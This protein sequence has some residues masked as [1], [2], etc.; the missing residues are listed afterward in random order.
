MYY[1]QDTNNSVTVTASSTGNPGGV[2]NHGF[3]SKSFAGASQG[4]DSLYHYST[5]TLKVGETADNYIAYFIMITTATYT[6]D[7]GG[8][9]KLQPGPQRQLRRYSR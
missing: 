7:A 4:Y 6:V 2:R 5:G 8:L 3:W 1:T 9:S